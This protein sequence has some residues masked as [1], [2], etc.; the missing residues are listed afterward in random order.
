[1]L[2]NGAGVPS[3]AV[4]AVLGKGLGV[5]EQFGLTELTYRIDAKQLDNDNRNRDTAAAARRKNKRAWTVHCK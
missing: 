4:P 5:Q 1:M 3:T 2:G